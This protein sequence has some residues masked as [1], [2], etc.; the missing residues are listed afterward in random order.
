M[1]NSRWWHVVPYQ[2]NISW[3]LRD[4]HAFVFSSGRYFKG[5]S[6]AD[7]E[8]PGSLREI[9]QRSRGRTHSVLDID[10]VVD[11]PPDEPHQQP[12]FPM[13]EQASSRLPVLHASN[14]TI[15]REERYLDYPDIPE[16]STVVRG[17]GV[18][19]LPPELV[20][21]VF[22]SERPTWYQAQEAEWNRDLERFGCIYVLLY[23][24]GDMKPTHILF[25]G[26]SGDE[27]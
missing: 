13:P 24:D 4:L 17:F 10:Y 1:G 12:L 19:P 23:D 16:G 11:L 25:C 14:G 20:R 2:E 8:W 27:P 7:D 3:A 26:W 15:L 5:D 18:Y 6:Y 21:R 9:R 22:G